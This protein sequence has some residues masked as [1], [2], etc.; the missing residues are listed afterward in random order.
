MI[1]RNTKQKN[2]KVTGDCFIKKRNPKLQPTGIYD[3]YMFTFHNTARKKHAGMQYT[4]IQL[5]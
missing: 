5:P 4:D 2:L 3:T 1:I